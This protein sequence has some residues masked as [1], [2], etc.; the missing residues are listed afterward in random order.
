MER[1][2]LRVGSA[3]PNDT[4]TLDELARQLRAQPAVEVVDTEAMP[5]RLGEVEI[6]AALGGA[7]V[8]TGGF[9]TAY[10]IVAEFL[11]RRHRGKLTIQSGD[12]EV[13]VDG[14]SGK[15]SE[16]ILRELFPDGVPDESGPEGVGE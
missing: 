5:R 10:E 11:K 2:L 8:F 12:R 9:T 15:D 1:I 14:S 6:V 7:G 4:A 13:V 3:D 16:T